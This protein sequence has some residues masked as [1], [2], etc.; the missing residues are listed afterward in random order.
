MNYEELRTEYRYTPDP[1]G[2]IGRIVKSE[3]FTKDY[4]EWLEVELLK[5]RASKSG[6]Q[7]PRA[8]N[9]ASLAIALLERWLRVAADLDLKLYP[10]LLEETRAVIAAQQQAGG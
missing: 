4:V 3:H 2:G 5:C 9:N 7:P 10:P 6:A 1:R 8:D